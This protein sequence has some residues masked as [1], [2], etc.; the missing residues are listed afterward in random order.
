M[1]HRAF[2]S[3]SPQERTNLDGSIVNP[4]ALLVD[5]ADDASATTL[6]E[7]ESS[8][9][10][11]HDAKSLEESIT[12]T[13]VAVSHDTVGSSSSTLPSSCEKPVVG[14]SESASAIASQDPDIS[15]FRESFDTPLRIGGSI[16]TDA[17]TDCSLPS[18]FSLGPP[19]FVR[20]PPD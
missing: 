10:K 7:P 5:V 2:S 6:E 1:T 20:N 3:V 15:S 8:L 12:G 13:P 14:A 18:S 9:E 19:I 4:Y 11:L 16:A 17:R